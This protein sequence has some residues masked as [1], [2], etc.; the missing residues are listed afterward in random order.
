MS[1][2]DYYSGRAVPLTVKSDDEE[3]GAVGAISR[4]LLDVFSRLEAAGERAKAAPSDQRLAIFDRALDELGDE[5]LRLV[6]NLDGLSKGDCIAIAEAIGA[7]VFENT[8]TGIIRAIK[9]DVTERMWHIRLRLIG[10]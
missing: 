10:V 3:T 8:K 5:A 2:H 1:A 7:S 4:Q 6:D 9:R